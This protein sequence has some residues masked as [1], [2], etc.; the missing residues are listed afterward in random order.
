MTDFPELLTRAQAANKDALADIW[1][2]WQPRLL[3]FLRAR[4]TLGPEDI[5]SIVWIHVA[6]GIKRFE[7]DEQDF[8]AWLFTIARR[9]VVDETRKWSRRPHEVSSPFE[10]RADE[11][12]IDVRDGL[13]WALD[14]IRMLPPDQA[15]AVLLRVLADLDVTRAA[16]VMGMSEGNVRVLTHRGLKRLAELVGTPDE[17]IPEAL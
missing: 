14:Q 17:E 5:A 4:N 15:E 12:A 2:Q 8:T 6:K 10:D 3:R 1:R 16:Q 7:G 13:E 11:D 9:R